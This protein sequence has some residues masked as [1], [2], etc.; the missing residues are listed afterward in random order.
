MGKTSG[1]V[2]FPH[3]HKNYT[4]NYQQVIH[5]LLASFYRI[6]SIVIVIQLHLFRKIKTDLNQAKRYVGKSI[7][8]YIHLAFFHIS[9][10]TTTTTKI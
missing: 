5:I 8:G 2:G 9:L 10:Y 6:V 7:I 3:Y 4:Q 1:Q